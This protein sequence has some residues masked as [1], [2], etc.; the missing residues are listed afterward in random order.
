MYRLAFDAKRAYQNYYGLGNYSR[1]L[2]STMIELFPENN[3]YLY[4]PQV[5]IHFID[6][7]VEH[8]GRVTLV[9][10]TS[11][12]KFVHPI[13]RN[14]FVPFDLRRKKIQLYHGLNNELLRGIP[15]SIP[16]V[17][18]IHDLNFL[19]HPELYHPSER[20]LLNKKNVYVCAHASKIITSSEYTKQEIIEA[21]SVPEYKIDVV[22]Q[23]CDVR[24]HKKQTD[25]EYEE[26]LQKYKIEKPYLLSVGTIE[27]KKNHL[28]I[29]KAFKMLN[30]KDLNLLFVGRSTVYVKEIQN[31]IVK[32]DLVNQVRIVTDIVSSD[33][34]AL[35]ANALC[36]I[37]A[38]DAEGF[39]IP[40]LESIYTD[41]PVITVK[42]TPM[43]EIASD[44]ALYFTSKNADEL[45]VQ[46]KKIVFNP[47][48]KSSLIS[49]G[50]SRLS[51]FD[52]NQSI[53]KT[54]A[55]YKTIIEG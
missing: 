5:K 40:V 43:S 23:D 19:K 25:N 33:M 48:I 11:L 49:E 44:A 28:T 15:K 6:H 47:E 50:R 3:Y 4:S 31:Y 24:F 7:L 8:K 38:S 51:L 29:L 45:M 12:P 37:F 35:Y 17:V 53:R 34:P 13:W 2:L 36:N 20:D 55:I 42:D 9:D 16:T 22:Y 41:C 30:E 14:A 18:T 46:M 27:E 52:K 1:H 21:Y 39:G 10:I 54:M 26:V 32:H